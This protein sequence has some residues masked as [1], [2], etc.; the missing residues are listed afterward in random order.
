[1]TTSQMNDLAV[2]LGMPVSL[3][4]VL[5]GVPDLRASIKNRRD[6]RT[7]AHIFNLLVT[8]SSIGHSRTAVPHPGLVDA[9]LLAAVTGVDGSDLAVTPITVSF[10]S[11]AGTTAE[12]DPSPESTLTYTTGAV[13]NL[14]PVAHWIPVSK[15]ALRHNAGLRA[16]VDAF[17]SGGLIVKLEQRIADELAA[18]AGTVAHPFDTDIATTVRTAIAAAQSAMREL[19]PGVVT[20]ALSPLDHAALDL[21]GHDLS[22][23]P[24][25]I[26]SSPALP[27]GFA[28]VGRLRLAASLYATA[29]T[30]SL[31]YINDQFGRNAAAILAS[32]DALAHVGAPGAIIKA[33]LT[34]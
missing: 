34:A 31:G 7:E 33:D 30:V 8:S 28:Y 16:D 18:T 2:E 14:E 20:V 21:A 22:Q 24:A 26:V 9:P 1:M 5:A 13:R 29:I 6:V 32:A 27:T 19:G 3:G 23:W 12:G 15:Q 25:T 10:T 11:A 17:L 4:D